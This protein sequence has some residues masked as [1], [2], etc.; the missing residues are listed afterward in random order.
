MAT[1]VR[2]T[3][4]ETPPS[5][6]RD[7]SAAAA[8][9]V[10]RRL[11]AKSGQRLSG[12]S[13]VVSEVINLVNGFFVKHQAHSPAERLAAIHLMHEVKERLRSLT[14]VPDAAQ[15]AEAGEHFARK[16]QSGFAPLASPQAVAARGHKPRRP[17]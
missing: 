15:L 9:V 16:S 12:V 17:H 3:K 1:I 6:P 2:P 11:P 7:R 10:V 8:T 14:A 5:D 4:K 13:I